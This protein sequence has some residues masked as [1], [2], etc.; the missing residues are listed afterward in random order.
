MMGVGSSHRIKAV[1][2]GETVR[3]RLGD[4]GFVVGAEVTVVNNLDGNLILEIGESR[5][6]LD[7]DLARRILV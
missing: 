3:R 1:G 2:G 4:L 6:A 5:V 7:A